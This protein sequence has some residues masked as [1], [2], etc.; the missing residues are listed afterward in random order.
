[1]QP[2]VVV[3]M[4]DHSRAAAFRA[5]SPCLRPHLEALAAESVQFQRCYTV[6]AI[7][8]PSRATLM[9]GCYPS[10]HGVWDCTHTQRAGWIDID[11]DLPHW[12]QRLR[13][14]GYRT[15]YFGKWHVEATQQADRFGWE[16]FDLKC[17]NWW[18]PRVP[19]SELAVSHEGYKDYLLAAT[20]D[21]SD[22]P[23]HHPAFD[24]GIDY[25]RRHAGA[26]PFCCFISVSEPH[27]PY[28]PPASFL[29][30][31][32]VDAMELPETLRTPPDGKPD[33]VARM[34]SLWTGLSDADWR[35]VLASYYAMVS[36]LDAEIGRAIQALKD[37]GVYD[38]TIVLVTADHGDMLGQHGLVA[39]GVGT[40]YEPV[41]NIPLMVRAPGLAAR[42]EET[43]LVSTV[44][45]APTILDLCGLDPLPRA[46]GR[47]LAPVLRAEHDAAA[48]QSAYA[49]FYG[50]RFVYTQRIT[51]DGDWKYVFSP[52]G[53]DELYNLDDDPLERHNLAD[54][55]AHRPKL[56]EM[57]RRMWARMQAIGDDSLLK[58]QYATLRTA[59]VG[60][61][62]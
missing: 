49:E 13:E 36:F 37:A 55:A 38:N 1:M 5:P 48:W 10:T 9:T 22:E 43:S 18:R 26:G 12:A 40:P 24:K 53:R 56:L 58:T 30:K 35:K 45:M 50:Q 2:N 28:V 3:L 25:I 23:P 20:A 27:D 14:A 17:G 52:G 7:C 62:A 6:N 46:Q 32:D 16:E 4:S 33:V 44:D 21:D 54:D 57:T 15:G 34:R 60:P 59:P 19:G 29:A 42:D 41:Y 47:S 11:N 31:Y 39:K 61:G 8:S 51:W